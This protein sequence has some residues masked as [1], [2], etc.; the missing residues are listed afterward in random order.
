MERWR[1]L[2]REL[3]AATCCQYR[4]FT[5][6]VVEHYHPVLTM[7]TIVGRPGPPDSCLAEHAVPGRAESVLACPAAYALQ[8]K[9]PLIRK[10]PGYLAHHGFQCFGQP[11]RRS[12]DIPGR[13]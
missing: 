3:G 13:R 4:H 7:R 11:G 6:E 8:D 12:R 9:L 2:P 10:H 1:W 5:L